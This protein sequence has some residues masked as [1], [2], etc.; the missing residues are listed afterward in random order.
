MAQEFLTG[1]ARFGLL[2]AAHDPA[3][4][5]FVESIRA[6]SRQPGMQREVVQAD[7]PAQFAVPFVRQLVRERVQGL[8]LQARFPYAS[9]SLAE[10]ALRYLARPGGNMTG[11]SANLPAMVGK[12]LQLLQEVTPGL[13]RAAF[14]GSTDDLAT[15]LFVEQARNT[16]G[17]L[18]VAMQ[19]VLVSQSREFAT[20]VQSMVRERAQV[21]IVQPLF[22]N[23]GAGPLAGLL[24]H[25][26]LPSVTAQRNYAVAGGLMAYGFSREEVSR[27]TASFVDRVLKGAAPA[28]LP[29]EEPTAY[30][31][32]VNL[33]TAKA[34]G[35]TVPNGVLL[36]ADEVIQ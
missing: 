7:A 1:P 16:A 24:A 34:I 13:Q 27:R 14:L 29:V 30:E 4:P 10:S 6:A 33:K 5:L 23:S 15:R 26:R 28:S 2:A 36:R 19:V 9:R 32:V 20:A 8:V 12:Q 11:V 18:G 21:V 17:L 31:L 3:A 25:N 22:S 35:V